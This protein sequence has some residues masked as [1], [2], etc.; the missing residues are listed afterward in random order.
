MSISLVHLSPARLIDTQL[1]CAHTAGAHRRR[2]SVCEQTRLCEK[3]IDIA[4]AP[5]L[6]GGGGGGKSFGPTYK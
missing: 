2:P 4:R 5:L 1:A 3:L 6:C